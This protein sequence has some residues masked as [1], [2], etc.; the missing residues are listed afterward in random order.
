MRL[1]AREATLSLFTVAVAL[2][3]TTAMMAG[4]KLD[5]WKKMRADL[6]NANRRIQGYEKLL[7]QKQ[8]WDG[9]FNKLREMLPRYPADKNVDIHW[10]S[11]MDRL[12]SRRGVRITRREV[13]EEKKMGDVY[14]L[15]IECRDWEGSLGAL[16]HFLV[17]L[18]S[19]GAMLDMRQLLVK[20]KSHN[21]LRGRFSLYCAYTREKEPARKP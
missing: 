13:R 1:S 2:F 3:A 20:P 7:S 4:P 11:T 15:P 10:L 16:V 5:E 17:D 14:E 19:E 18:E 8:M 12:A 9:Q 6:R 21:L